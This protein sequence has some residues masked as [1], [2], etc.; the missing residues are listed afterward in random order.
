[1]SADTDALRDLTVAYCWALDT[2]SFDD[3]DEVFTPD[4]TAS[5][6]GTFEGI[7]SIKQRVAD[8]LNPLDVSQHTVSTHQFRIDGDRATGRCYL[9]A[10]HVRN[11]GQ[12][13]VAGRYEDEYLRTPDGW[14]IAHRDLV[15]MW[16]AGDPTILR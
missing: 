1:M 3:L 5:L 16:T 11:G 15:V 2:R 4:A 13:I 9:H 10:Q 8:A 7:A 14:R 12:Y 6:G